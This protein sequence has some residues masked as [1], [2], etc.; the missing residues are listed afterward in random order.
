MLNYHM[1]CCSRQ[2][3]AL[4]AATW[5]DRFSWCCCQRFSQFLTCPITPSACQ[6][7][8]L[9]IIFVPHPTLLPSCNEQRGGDRGTLSQQG[10][11]LAAQLQHV[12][13]HWGEVL[14]NPDCGCMALLWKLVITHW[15]CCSITYE[16]RTWRRFSRE[17]PIDR[18]P[19]AKLVLVLYK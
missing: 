11:C 14:M 8:S 18:S 12:D 16:I 3:R 6:S 4:I 19:N 13:C 7:E 17:W 5:A 10:L 15:M 2:N 9:F 1:L